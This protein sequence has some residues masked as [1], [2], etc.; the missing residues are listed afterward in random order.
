MNFNARKKRI[1]IALKNAF[2]PVSIEV[3]DDSKQHASHKSIEEGA[4]ETHF[5]I[6]ADLHTNKYN[7]P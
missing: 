5:Y 6:K 1:E 2:D 3:R 7:K 4:T